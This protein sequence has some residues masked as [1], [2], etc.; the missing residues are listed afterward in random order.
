MKTISKFCVCLIILIATI[1]VCPHVH[2]QECGFDATTNSG[3]I[4]EHEESCYEEKE[5]I[6]SRACLGPDCP[7]F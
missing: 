3:C 1:L 7:E 5:I 2:N 6:Q 4:H